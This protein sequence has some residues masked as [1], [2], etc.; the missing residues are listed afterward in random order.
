MSRRAVHLMVDGSTIAKCGLRSLPQTNLTFLSERVTCRSCKALPIPVETELR[1]GRLRA[2]EVEAIR[3][4]VASDPA[5]HHLNA[6]AIAE[7]LH[8]RGIRATRS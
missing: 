7:R 6:A 5:T 2:Y 8:M 4:I 3:K 1:E